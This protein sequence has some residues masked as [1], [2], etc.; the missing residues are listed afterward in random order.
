MMFIFAYEK[1]REI[2]KEYTM[3]F[4]QTALFLLLGNLAAEKVHWQ[5]S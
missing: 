2:L 1:D 3:N 5:G 4:L